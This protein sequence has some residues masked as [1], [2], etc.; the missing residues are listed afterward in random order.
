MYKYPYLS[1]S[2]QGVLVPTFLFRYHRAVLIRA[3]FRRSKG[4]R[5]APGPTNQR[6]LRNMEELAPY[7][8]E[9]LNMEVL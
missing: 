2:I 5:S 7:F 3:K 8:L 1:I 9:C 6:S 4:E